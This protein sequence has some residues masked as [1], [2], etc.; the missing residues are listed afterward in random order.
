MKT[1]FETQFPASSTFLAQP[2][3]TVARNAIEGGDVKLAKRSKS[4][5]I[6]AAVGL[7]IAGQM[8][9]ACQPNSGGHASGPGASA[10][11]PGTPSAPVLG[12]AGTGDSSGGDGINN[13]VFEA[14][15]LDI[16]KTPEWMNHI[17]PIERHFKSLP[18]LRSQDANAMLSMIARSKRWYI[19]PVSLDQIEKKNLGV[20]FIKD[21]IQQLALQTSKSI[22]IDKEKYEDPRNSEH[23][24][25]YLQMHET[26]VALYV[27]RFLPAEE[28]CRQLTEDPAG[29]SGIDLAKFFGPPETSRKLEKED[30]ERIRAMT[31]WMM[32]HAVE[33][34]SQ[35]EFFVE[36]YR[37]HFDSRFFK[38]DPDVQPTE[39]GSKPSTE[40]EGY[41]KFVKVDQLNRASVLATA[42]TLGRLPTTCGVEAQGLRSGTCEVTI[43]LTK[44]A[45]GDYLLQLKFT[46]QTTGGQVLNYVGTQVILA[47]GGQIEMRKE[48]S[49]MSEHLQIYQQNLG[50]I[51]PI[52]E[53]TLAVGTDFYE[54]WIH[55]SADLQNVQEINFSQRRITS[56]PKIEDVKSN[57]L[58]ATRVNFHYGAV[59]DD[60]RQDI[61]MVGK[62]VSVDK[63]GYNYLT[64][65][66]GE[67]VELIN[68]RSSNPK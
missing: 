47:N 16:T 36:L 62:G 19:A 65:G 37:Q 46:L 52:G 43:D 67:L 40:G 20:E 54:V 17:A 7:L 33:S 1:Q 55:W 26:M 10:P 61:M 23:D 25:A 49:R 21:P 32:N 18:K 44:A 41:P 50:F 34:K 2:S 3:D 68:Y 30:Y 39:G 53:N 48:R 4:Q 13:K 57:G 63:A 56:V 12:G 5:I 31:N 51:F 38:A 28:V 15:S 64:T 60:T 22:W 11:A 58:A 9:V 14:Y 42:K 59:A 35:K 45:S 6:A 29:C 27:I 24:R 66:S 8:M